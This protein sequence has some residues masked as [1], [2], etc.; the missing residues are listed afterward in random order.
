MLKLKFKKDEKAQSTLEYLIV[1]A[2]LIGLMITAGRTIFKPAMSQALT[3]LGQ[4]VVSAA[5][6]F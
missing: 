2:V 4:S 1:L 5:N 6:S 3:K